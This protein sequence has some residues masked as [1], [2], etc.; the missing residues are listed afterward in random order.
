[1]TAVTLNERQRGKIM[2][3]L[4]TCSGIYVGNETKTIRF[5]SAILWIVRSGA[6]WEFLPEQYGKWNSVY[7]RFARWCERGIW[8]QMHAHFADDPDLEWLLLDSTIIRAHPCA[9]GALRIGCCGLL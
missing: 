9:A 7:K 2:S 5:I 3:F 6:P 1:V 4:A 8:T